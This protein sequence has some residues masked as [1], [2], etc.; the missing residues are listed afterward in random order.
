MHHLSKPPNFSASKNLS[1]RDL[2]TY[3]LIFFYTF[4]SLFMGDRG[5]WTIAI[6]WFVEVST[7]AASMSSSTW[8]P[9][10]NKNIPPKVRWKECISVIQM[11]IGFFWPWNNLKPAKWWWYFSANWT[12]W[13]WTIIFPGALASWVKFHSPKEKTINLDPQIIRLGLT[14]FI[15]F[16]CWSKNFIHLPR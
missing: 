13:N 3:W 6:W 11:L 10:T 9:E 8:A 16:S 5:A 1:F 12:F 15:A 7:L 4:M 2:C 14:V